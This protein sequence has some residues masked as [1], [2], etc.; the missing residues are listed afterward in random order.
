MRGDAACRC[1]PTSYLS[2]MSLLRRWLGSRVSAVACAVAAAS[3]CSSEAVD[4]VAA[5]EPR[6]VVGRVSGTD[7]AIAVVSDASQSVG[8]LCGGPTTLSPWTRWLAGD[9]ALLVG[10]DAT[11]SVE[12]DDGG[13]SGTV[14]PAD[15]APIPWQGAQASGSAGLYTAVDAG[16]RTGVVVETETQAQGA[17][18]NS[19]GWLEQ[20]TPVT[21]IS[22]EGFEVQVEL[23]SG[24]RQLVVR[25]FGGAELALQP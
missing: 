6:T 16:C 9:G 8:Y 13:L 10:A 14:Y 12:I 23:A 19:Q 18:C 7:V 20:V 1:T 11:W 21:P 3:G 17:W 5:V 25:R 15:G 2:P 4:P 22:V 24:E